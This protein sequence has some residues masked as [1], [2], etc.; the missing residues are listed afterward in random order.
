MKGGD[1]MMESEVR[2]E[3]YALL[4]AQK[5]EERIMDQKM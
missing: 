3:E 2:E 4:L 1:M 5:M